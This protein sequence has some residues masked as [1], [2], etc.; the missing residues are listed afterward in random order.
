MNT[1][2][3]NSG[4]YRLL[5]LNSEL[6]HFLNMII[7][8]V[9]MHFTEAGVGNFLEIFKRHQ[10][11]IRSVEGCTHLE[12]LKDLNNPLVYT[13]MSYWQHAQ[14]LENYRES[15]LFKNVWGQ[16]KTLFAARTEAFSLEKVQEL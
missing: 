16:V 14:N 10:A 4:L 7:R 3:I 1:S 9:R 6:Q 5:N 8:I 12:L 15:D 11:A 2:L 13:T